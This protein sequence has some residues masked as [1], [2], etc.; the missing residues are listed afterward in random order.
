MLQGNDRLSR[1][2]RS[3]IIGLGVLTLVYGWVVLHRSAY[4]QY[5]HTDAGVY[6]RA[7]WAV[8][9]GTSIYQVRD[10]SNLPYVSTPFLAILL[11]PLADPPAGTPPEKRGYG[12]PYPASIAFFYAISVAALFGAMHILASAIEGQSRSPN[13]RVPEPFGRRWWALRL[14]PILI[15]A[16]MIAT[17][18]GRGQP[19]LVILFCLA[20]MTVAFMRGRSSL[21]GW[22]L[23]GAIC[24]KVFPAYLLLYPLWRRDV[25]CLVTC[26]AGLL[27]G[28][29][30]VP[31]AIMGPATAIATYQEYFDFFL[32]PAFTG[33]DNLS[34]SSG[35]WDEIH[36]HLQSFKAVLFRIAYPDPA[37]RPN[38]IPRI[39][40]IAHLALSAVVAIVSLVAAGWRKRSDEMPTDVEGLRSLL[41]VGI[42]TTGVLPMIPASRDHY[43]ALATISLIGMVAMAWRHNGPL[44]V[45]TGWVVFFGA[46]FALQLAVQV[47]RLLPID[48]LGNV[49]WAALILWLAGVYQLWKLTDPSKKSVPH[50]NWP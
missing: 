48:D 21:A 23:A 17:T 6:F 31:A 37:Q 3:L 29:I 4:L 38:A 2:E 26:F 49:I 42:L 11:T 7:A 14:T 16:P 15:C 34:D 1:I 35:W 39:F 32:R 28:L 13:S 30:V 45:S 5:R 44:R 9:S 33:A 18:L 12:L 22:W 43:F 25:R 24:I 50:N 10:D 8:Q 41:F 40:W 47:P 20:A 46:I 36:G 19:T 27:V